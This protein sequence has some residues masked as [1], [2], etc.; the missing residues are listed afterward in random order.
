MA[1]AESASFWVLIDGDYGAKPM[2]VGSSSMSVQ[3]SATMA[4][5]LLWWSYLIGQWL[6]PIEC[7]RQT[8]E[9]DEVVRT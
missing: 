7:W 8:I 9:C 3:E 6:R 4:V 1:S 2:V 5:V